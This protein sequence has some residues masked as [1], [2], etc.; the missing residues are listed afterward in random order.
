[1]TGRP[2]LDGAV[3][4]DPAAGQ[5]VV[6]AALTRRVADLEHRLNVMKIIVGL[7]LAGKILLVAFILYIVFGGS[8]VVRNTGSIRPAAQPARQVQ[9]LNSVP[10]G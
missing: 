8:L 9:S 7:V 1:M 4:L 3:P 2:R 10:T 6:L 5:D